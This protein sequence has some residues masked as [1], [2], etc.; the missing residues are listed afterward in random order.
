MRTA[1]RGKAI[2][3]SCIYFDCLFDAAVYPFKIYEMETTIK[4]KIHFFPPL[5]QYVRHVKE[6]WE[7]M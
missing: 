6:R 1:W 5:P 2:P 4:E 3:E 7:K